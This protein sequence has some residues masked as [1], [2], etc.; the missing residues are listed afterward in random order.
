M[1]QVHFV[2]GILLIYAKQVIVKQYLLLTEQLYYII[3]GSGQRNSLL[4]KIELGRT[5]YSRITGPWPITIAIYGNRGTR[6]INRAGQD[7]L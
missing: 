6:E 5:Y 3:L 7:T 4:E 1:L 2:T